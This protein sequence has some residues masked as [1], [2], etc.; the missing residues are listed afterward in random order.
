MM[1]YSM[2]PPVPLTSPQAGNES[3]IVNKLIDENY[4]VLLKS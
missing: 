1:P 4:A 3:L 2:H